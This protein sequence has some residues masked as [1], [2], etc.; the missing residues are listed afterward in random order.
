MIYSYIIIGIVFM[1]CIDILIY[2]YLGNKRPDILK[3]YNT[4]GITERILMIVLWPFCLLV[5]V[6]AIIDQNEK[7]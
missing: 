6:K 7:N 5:F 4:L 3:A 2:S 1:L